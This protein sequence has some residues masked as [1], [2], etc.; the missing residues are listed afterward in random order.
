VEEGK[1]TGAKLKDKRLDRS[2]V[3]WYTRRDGEEARH[4]T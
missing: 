3:A 1:Q 4:K 2:G